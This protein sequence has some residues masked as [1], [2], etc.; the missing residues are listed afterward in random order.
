MSV[1]VAT[2]RKKSKKCGFF[3]NFLINS[4]YSEYKGAVTQGDSH[5][6]I[7]TINNH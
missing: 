6:S 2:A 4:R 5:E 3:N 7:I 1:F